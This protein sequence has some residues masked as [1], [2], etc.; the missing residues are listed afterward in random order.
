MLFVGLE[1]DAR[2]FRWG[3]A[4]IGAALLG[5]VISVIAVALPARWASAQ[6]V[7]VRPLLAGDK[8]S[9]ASGAVEGSL[10]WRTGNTELLLVSGNVLAR[11]RAG[12]HRVFMM[13]RAELGMQSGGRFLD[14]DFEHL[15]Y[16]WEAFPRVHLETFAQ[17]DRDEFRRLSLRALWGGGP[18]SLLVSSKAFELELGIAYMLE[19]ERLREGPESDAGDTTLA[20]R[21]SA[22]IAA[23][24]RVEKGVN[25]GETIYLQPR[26]DRP[27]DV[28]VLSET[29]LLVEFAKRFAL[30]VAF[31]AMVDSE[32]PIG[33]RRLDTTL[34]SSLQFRF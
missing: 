17:H 3:G 13:T 4:R 2:W 30:K 26:L 10:D 16:Q 32:P 20:H 22:C 25:L 14:K 11:Y 8:E 33:L 27:R 18:R 12:V 6:I 21:A 31:A 15:R 28:R 34:K 7:N 19:I 24:L 5:T 1:R 9:G 23:V 29:E